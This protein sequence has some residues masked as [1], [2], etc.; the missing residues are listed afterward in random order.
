LSQCATS[1][2]VRAI[3]AM[4]SVTLSDVDSMTRV[5]ILSDADATSHSGQQREGETTAHLHT[6]MYVNMLLGICVCHH[7]RSV[8]QTVGG[9]GVGSD[10]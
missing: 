4:T 3:V 10:A 9:V 2:I 7:S 8:M 6:S 1:H 5:V